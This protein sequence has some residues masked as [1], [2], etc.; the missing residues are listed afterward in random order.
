MCLRLGTGS[1]V[2]VGMV[3]RL[4]P[5]RLECI[6]RDS[7]IYIHAVRSAVTILTGCNYATTTECEN[8]I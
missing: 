4:E 7:P 1:K 8:Y 3:G 2:G 6:F 5:E